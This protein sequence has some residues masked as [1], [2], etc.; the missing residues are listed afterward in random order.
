[1]ERK[2]G[3]SLSLSFPLTQSMSAALRAAIAAKRA[4]LK[5]APTAQQDTPAGSQESNKDV[6]SETDE[7]AAPVEDL[8]LAQPS[9]SSLLLKSC[10]SGKLLLSSRSPELTRLPNELFDLLKEAPPAWYRGARPWYER[11]DLVSLSV[12]N[13]A[14][15]ECA[16]RIEEFTALQRLDVSAV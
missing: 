13:N 4:A 10:T 1:M 12:A 2:Q 15:V 14:L 8:S 9:L 16:G 7:L 5:Q 11:S 6:S 3:A